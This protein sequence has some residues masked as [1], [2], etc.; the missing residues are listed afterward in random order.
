MKT[1]LVYFLASFIAISVTAQINVGKGVVP[2]MKK[3]KIDEEDLNLLK[4]TT[5]IFFLSDKDE[6]KL[7]DYKK[8]FADA[9]SFNKIELVNIKYK[10]NY[11][12]KPNY[13][14][15]TLSSE[16][17]TTTN[18]SIN[19]NYTATNTS[20][21]FSTISNYNFLSLWMN[22]KI[23]NKE[24]I[25]V[26]GRIELHPAINATPNRSA[27]DHSID[28]NNVQFSN[29]NPGFLKAYLLV[30]NNYLTLGKTRYLFQNEVNDEQLKKLKHDTL[31]I[32]DYILI[33]YIDPKSGVL[34]KY[35]L[36]EIIQN[37]PFPYRVVSEKYLSNKIL[38]SQKEINYL[39]FVRSSGEKFVTVF[40]S[41]NGISFN[42]HKSS[43]Y[44]IKSK[45][46]E[47][48]AIKVGNL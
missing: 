10:N 43:A 47:E 14:F 9:W 4:S 29:L 7:N 42:R 3:G 33:K 46:L 20:T 2:E 28:W 45:D 5:T 38:Y 26:F 24:K 12:G 25:L 21:N 6:P 23:K 22:K 1:I 34:T 16:S 19:E 8:A 18:T 35:N 32:P 41:N 44:Y 39:I 30:L 31:F 15:L 13:S 11:L 17:N 27:N 37:Y 36:N 48:I 40:N